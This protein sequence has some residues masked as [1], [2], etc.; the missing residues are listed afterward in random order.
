MVEGQMARRVMATTILAIVVACSVGGFAT[1]AT[2]APSP[3]PKC[4]VIKNG[5]LP[6]CEQERD[7]TWTAIY[8]NTVGKHGDSNSGADTKRAVELA[9]VVAAIIGIATIV[10]RTWIRP[11]ARTPVGSSA[12]DIADLPRARLSGASV[13][14]PL[15]HAKPPAQVPPAAPPRSAAQQL[16]ELN[17][18][19]NQGTISQDEYE[20]RRLAIVSGSS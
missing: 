5:A 3:P 4:F 11:A 18:L 12:P 20:A 14:P 6:L 15:P 19:R 7:G 9:I 16:A 13:E 17:A 2:P 10:W 8:P 1:A